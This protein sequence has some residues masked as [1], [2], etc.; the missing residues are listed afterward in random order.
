M[1]QEL[2]KKLCDVSST[3]PMLKNTKP[4]GAAIS[5]RR[6]LL[7]HSR[8]SR[9]RIANLDSGAAPTGGPGWP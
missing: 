6:H 1:W 8:L 3:L 4:I 2:Q 5:H 9:S 7:F